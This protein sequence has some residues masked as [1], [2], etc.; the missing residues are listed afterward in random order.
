MDRFQIHRDR[1][2]IIIALVG[3]RYHDQFRF[4]Q[5]RIPAVSTRWQ[6]S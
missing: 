5:N 3:E 6:R 1:A 2:V 4:L